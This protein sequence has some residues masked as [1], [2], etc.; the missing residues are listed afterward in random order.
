MKNIMMSMVGVSLLGLMSISVAVADTCSDAGFGPGMHASLPSGGNSCDGGRAPEDG[1]GNPVTF[2]YP[3][4]VY[5]F[6]AASPES[7]ALQ[8]HGTLTIHPK[9]WGVAPLNMNESEALGRFSYVRSDG[10]FVVAE[11]RVYLQYLTINNQPRYRI[12]VSSPEQ[13]NAQIIV[14]RVLSGGALEIDVFL[15]WSSDGGSF[16]NLL[17]CFM[18]DCQ[19]ASFLA[20]NTPT[21]FRVGRVDGFNGSDNN[22]FHWRLAKQ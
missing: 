14:P 22:S 5:R 10:S 16:G 13:G 3:W 7:T 12:L 2:T 8:V 1:S 9:Q 4:P 19:F 18:N 15:R 20:P 17:L 6:D 21:P 11:K